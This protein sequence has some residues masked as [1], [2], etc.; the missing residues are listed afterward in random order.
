MKYSIL[1]KVYYSSCKY[2]VLSLSSQFFQLN[3]CSVSKFQSHLGRQCG[4]STQTN[5]DGGAN[6]LIF[7]LKKNCIFRHQDFDLQTKTS[8]AETLR[9]NATATCRFSSV[10]PKDHMT[11]PFF[12]RHS[13]FVCVYIQVKLYPCV[14]VHVSVCLSGVFCCCIM[15]WSIRESACVTQQ[16]TTAW[17]QPRKRLGEK[18]QQRSA[19]LTPADMNIIAEISFTCFKALA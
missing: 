6:Q 13:V 11:L 4:C 15:A 17:S 16:I 19:A 12:F 3:F 1:I 2:S 9:L 7:C 18:W 14:Y 10:I 8:Y 5:D